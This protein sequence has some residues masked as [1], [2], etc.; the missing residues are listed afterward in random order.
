MVLRPESLV[1]VRAD[2]VEPLIE[3]ANNDRVLK[4]RL[5]EYATEEIVFCMGV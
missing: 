4:K 5:G 3:V 1:V 2:E